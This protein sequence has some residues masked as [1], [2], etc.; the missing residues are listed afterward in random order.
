MAEASILVT[1]FGEKKVLT[2]AWS[3]P[4]LFPAWFWIVSIEM[5]LSYSCPSFISTSS[6]SAFPSKQL[7]V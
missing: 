5:F 6:I 4:L 1:S 3:N 7:R 2:S